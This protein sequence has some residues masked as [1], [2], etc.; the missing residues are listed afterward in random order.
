MVWFVIKA[1]LGLKTMMAVVGHL[2]FLSFDR[3]TLV[4]YVTHN[5]N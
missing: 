3:I 1:Y 2:E 5:F 4:S